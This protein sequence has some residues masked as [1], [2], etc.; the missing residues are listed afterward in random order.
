MQHVYSKAK[1]E[2]PIDCFGRL[3]D[4]TKIECQICLVSRQCQRTES[5]LMRG[6]QKEKKKKGKL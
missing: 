6:E 1:K 5:M 3:H 4:R 2:T